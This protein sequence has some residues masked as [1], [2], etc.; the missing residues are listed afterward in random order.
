[1]RRNS[2]L[3]GRR[4]LLSRGRWCPN[5]CT[6]LRLWVLGQVSMTWETMPLSWT[7]L[8]CQS[9]RIFYV[10]VISISFCY[11]NLLISYSYLSYHLHILFVWFN[12]HKVYME[13]GMGNSES[14]VVRWCVG[15]MNVCSEV[16]WLYWLIPV[17]FMTGPRVYYS[18]YMFLSRAWARRRALGLPWCTFRSWGQACGICLCSAAWS[19][20]VSPSITTLSGEESEVVTGVGAQG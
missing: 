13:T 10:Y 9:H 11:I 8:F 18:L 5:T 1:M 7:C 12:L 19:P 2:N 3:W 4:T 16:I 6:P 17:Q 14:H 15:M 20:F